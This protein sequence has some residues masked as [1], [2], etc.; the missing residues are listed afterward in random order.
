M[1]RLDFSLQSPVAVIKLINMVLITED[2]L[3]VNMILKALTTNETGAACIFTGFVRQ[4]TKRGKA[5]LTNHLEYESYFPMAEAK[6]LQICDEMRGKWPLINKD[7]Y[8]TK[9]GCFITR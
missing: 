3:D 7:F 5:H 8:G 4:D 2:E 9:I 1:M 6:M